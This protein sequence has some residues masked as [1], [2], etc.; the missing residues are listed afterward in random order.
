MDFKS[1]V[2][3]FVSLQ[4]SKQGLSTNV[5]TSFFN[6]LNPVLV[7]C[8]HAYLFP[9]ALFLSMIFLWWPQTNDL[10]IQIVLKPQHQLN[11]CLRCKRTCCTIVLWEKILL[12]EEAKELMNLDWKAPLMQTCLTF[13]EQSTWK[14]C[15][16]EISFLWAPVVLCVTKFL[17][18][19][20]KLKILCATIRIFH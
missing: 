4:K 1:S 12:K 19:K 14:S 9:I 10:G 18:Y 7:I 3:F 17:I 16:A 11:L 20:S 13:H 6:N 8:V 15:A 5:Q 2:G